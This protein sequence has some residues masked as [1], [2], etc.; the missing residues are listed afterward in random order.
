LLR[1]G[2]LGYLNSMPLLVGIFH[3]IDYHETMGV[4]ADSIPCVC[5]DETKKG[6][7]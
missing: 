4:S 5:C 7:R 6:S 3:Y 1:G 2:L